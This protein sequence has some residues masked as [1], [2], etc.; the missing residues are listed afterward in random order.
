MFVFEFVIDVV[1]VV[2]VWYEFLVF[3]VFVWFLYC[4]VGLGWYCLII[5]C[6]WAGFVEWGC[7]GV[8]LL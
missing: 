6:Y 1:V 8:V 2:G 5:G 7:V 4:Y 3:N